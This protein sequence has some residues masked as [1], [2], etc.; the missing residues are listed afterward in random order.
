MKELVEHVLNLESSFFRL[1]ATELRRFANQLGGKY[2]LKHRFNRENE[3]PGKKWYYKLMKDNPW[4]SL[5][6]PEKTSMARAF[7]KECVYG[8]F[9]KYEHI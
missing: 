5:R 2:K 8:F 3:I 4:L 9:D 1:A 6:T 7:N